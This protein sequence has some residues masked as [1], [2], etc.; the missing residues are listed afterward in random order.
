MSRR[1]SSASFASLARYGELAA[2][3]DAFFAR[4][5]GRHG[6]AMQCRAGCSAC[7]V[8]GL[9]VTG[10]EAEAI[11][12]GLAAMP[13]EER[14]RLRERARGRESARGEESAAC[15]A[16]DEEG[17]CSIYAARPLVCRSHGLPIRM[18]SGRG[19]PV[20]DAC[21]KN[22]ASGGP[23]AVEADCVLDQTT[24]STVL[25][26]VDREHAEATGRAAG[27]RIALAALL[28]E[29]GCAREENAG[30]SLETHD[31]RPLR[32]SRPSHL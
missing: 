4:V 11:R 24:L 2:K 26:A 30:P 16:L 15:P 22:F 27:E 19:L 13:D 25:H 21:P 17:R 31:E 28:M 9:S 18:P 3:V 32:P 1:Y 12:E 8:A 6:D 5:A 10:V 20:I 14:A 29:D 23:G 7:C